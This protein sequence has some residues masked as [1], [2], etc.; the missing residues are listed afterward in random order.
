MRICISGDVS[1][2]HPPYYD[3]VGNDPDVDEMK[4]VVVVANFRPEVLVQ[5][6]DHEVSYFSDIA[7]NREIFNW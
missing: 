7:R 3:V 4:K 5:W 2:Y 6:T 1:I